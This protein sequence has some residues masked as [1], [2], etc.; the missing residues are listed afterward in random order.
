MMPVD[1]LCRRDHIQHCHGRL[2]DDF[3]ISVLSHLPE[4]AHHEKSIRWRHHLCR[5]LDISTDLAPD[6][7]LLADRSQLG[8]QC[9]EC[10]VSSECV[11][12]VLQCD[13]NIGHRCH[14]SF[15]ASSYSLELE[16]EQQSTLGGIGCVRH[17]RI[18]S[19]ISRWHLLR[20]RCKGILTHMHPEFPLC[21]L[22][23]SGV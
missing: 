22:V 20:L 6:P 21:R 2:E 23:V 14:C 9:A 12:D 3:P 1:S 19:Y 7:D 8:S 10:Q 15:L 18:V 11:V 5:R 16:A 13:R 4:R 17:W